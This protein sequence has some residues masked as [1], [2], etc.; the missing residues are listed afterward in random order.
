MKIAVLNGSPR[1]KDS[2]NVIKEFESVIAKTK[3]VEFDWIN[4]KLY[5]NY[6][7]NDLSSGYMYND[8]IPGYG[9]SKISAH[10]YT[11]I[12]A[13]RFRNA[14]GRQF[15]VNPPREEIVKLLIQ[16]YTPNGTMTYLKDML[17]SRVFKAVYPKEKL[18]FNTYLEYNQ[19]PANDL[20]CQ[21]A[22]WF[23]QSLLLAER[24]DMDDIAAAIDKIQ[25][26]AG[27]IKVQS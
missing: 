7:D 16:A 13:W 3:T 10:G 8:T 26:H 17:S 2:F 21:E 22:V 5:L 6:D 20:L 15:N 18:N 11:F 27:E 23:S 25:K 24:R 9:I 19:C 12:N 4:L 1:K 14:E